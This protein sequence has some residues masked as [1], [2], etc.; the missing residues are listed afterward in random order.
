MEIHRSTLSS[1]HTATGLVVAIDVLRAFTTAAYLFGAGVAEILLVS[2]VQE[3]L[4]LRKAMPDCLLLGE[5]DGVKV[6]GFDLGNSPSKILGKNFS[7]KRVIQ[8][9]SAGTQ[10]VVLASNASAILTAA[11]TNL[12]ATARFIEKLAPQTVTLIQTGLFPEE[13]GGDEDAAC[14]DVIEAMLL[15]RVVD[16][17]RIAQRVRL[18]RSGLNFDGTCPDFPPKDLE[19]ALQFDRFRFAMVVERKNGLH[20]MY[21]V[22]A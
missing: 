3:A 9:T 21:C 5:V 22:E 1:C 15:G 11:L 17:N 20:L 16:W 7:G 8:R 6:P 13:G 19:L 12:S 14:A 2:G 4:E 10:G 18:S